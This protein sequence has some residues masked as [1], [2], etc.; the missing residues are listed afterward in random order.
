MCA[1]ALYMSVGVCLSVCLSVCVSLYRMVMVTMTWTKHGL[2]WAVPCT[3]PC[4]IYSPSVAV[5]YICTYV[6]CMYYVYTT[7][8]R[9]YL[10]VCIDV[11]SQFQQSAIPMLLK[12]AIVGMYISIIYIHAIYIHTYIQY[13]LTHTHVRTYVRSPNCRDIFSHHTFMTLMSCGT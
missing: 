10:P 6:Y 8:V 5:R 3:V 13:I 2:L 12:V 7:Y 9:T 1:H 4:S 11:H